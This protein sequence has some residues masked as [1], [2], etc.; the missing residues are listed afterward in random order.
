MISWAARSSRSALLTS[1]RRLFEHASCPVMHHW[2]SVNVREWHPGH[3]ALDAQLQPGGPDCL[4]GAPGNVTG[5]A[6]G[7][8]LREPVNQLSSLLKARAL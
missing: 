8:E 2:R 6:L 7:F 1:A 3:Q 5:Y 4:H